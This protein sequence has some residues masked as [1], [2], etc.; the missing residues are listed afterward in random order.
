LL[1]SSGGCRYNRRDYYILI[2]REGRK[3]FDFGINAG[4]AAADIDLGKY[5][6]WPDAGRI[7]TNMARLHAEFSGTITPD[8][9]FNA[10]VKARDEYTGLTSQR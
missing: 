5:K 10:F 6:T 4:R 1:F 8:S 7:A 2:Q 9:D 3:R